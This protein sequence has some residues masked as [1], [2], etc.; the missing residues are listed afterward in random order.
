MNFHKFMLA[1][2]AAAVLTIPGMNVSA[3]MVEIDLTDSGSAT[4]IQTTGDLIDETNTT[5]GEFPLA[6]DVVSDTEKGLELIIASIS[7]FDSAANPD[8]TEVFATNGSFG[9]NSPTP[10]GGSEN[11]AR[12]DVDAAEILELGFNQN[13]LILSVD[14]VNLEGN[15]EFN[16]DGVI[17]TDGDTSGSDEFDFTVGDTSP[18]IFLAEGDTIFLQAVGTAGTSVGL[19]GITVQVVPEPSSLLAIASVAGLFMMRRRR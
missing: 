19:D 10:D 2:I 16:F 15:E 1:T 7:S 5:S 12:F 18:G 4:G 9:I 11:A 14:L 13:V 3:D 6:F 17:I 8:D